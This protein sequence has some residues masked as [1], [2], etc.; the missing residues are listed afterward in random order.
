MLSFMQ[1][2][3]SGHVLLF[4]DYGIDIHLL[5]TDCDGFILYLF[6]NVVDDSAGQLLCPFLIIDIGNA[7]EKNNDTQI[8]E[9][10][11][12]N[13]VGCHL[14]INRPFCGD[15]NVRIFV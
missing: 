6:L 4:F 11:I 5:P 14:K 2:F 1:L 15:L 9:N 7:H 12:K 13:M 8:E 10:I 3:S